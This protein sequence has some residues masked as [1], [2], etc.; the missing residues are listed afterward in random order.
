MKKIISVFV[1]LFVCTINLNA[2]EKNTDSIKEKA[3]SELA[4]L[5]QVVQLDNDTSINVVNLLESKHQN[6]ANNL[7]QERKAI[8]AKDISN[9]LK[10]ILTPEQL[11]A[12][13]AKPELMK[14]LCN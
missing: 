9:K 11:K 2:Q 14:K 13:E 3:K 1:F 5:L 7:S 8:L 4:Q 10:G 6:L 12:V